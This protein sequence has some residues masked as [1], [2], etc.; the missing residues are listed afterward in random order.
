M[1]SNTTDPADLLL[2]AVKKATDTA[3]E[4]VMRF[5]EESINKPLDPEAKPKT[6]AQRRE[7]FAVYVATPHL[8]RSEFD[9]L[10]ARFNIPDDQLEFI[11][12]SWVNH[13]RKGR[14]EAR[15]EE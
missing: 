8:M 15:E 13:L 3:V 1:P 12:R 2:G 14:K 7:H 9:R 4:S 6:L 11:P 5:D 10:S